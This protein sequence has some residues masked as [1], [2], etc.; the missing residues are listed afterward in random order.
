MPGPGLQVHRSCLRGPG[1]VHPSLEDPDSA[2]RHEASAQ[3]KGQEC[4]K[5]GVRSQMGVDSKIQK[6]Q[7]W[8]KTRLPPQASKLPGLAQ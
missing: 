4:A 5:K 2:L 6:R 3:D 7:Q 1:L 8:L